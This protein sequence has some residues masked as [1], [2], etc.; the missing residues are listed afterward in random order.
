MAV[1]RH[2]EAVVAYEGYLALRPRQFKGW[3]NLGVSYGQMGRQEEALRCFERAVEIAPDHPH[4]RANRDR[5]RELVGQ[6]Q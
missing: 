4:A 5:A 1:K 2:Q 3:M 6:R